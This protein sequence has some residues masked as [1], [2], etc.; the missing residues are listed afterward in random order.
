M[1]W[2]VVYEE[3]VFHFLPYQKDVKEINLGLGFF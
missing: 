2:R 3:L 1:T